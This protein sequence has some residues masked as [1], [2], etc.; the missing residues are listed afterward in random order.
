MRPMRT[1]RKFLDLENTIRHSLKAFGVRLNL[2]ELHM[3]TS[4][5]PFEPNIASA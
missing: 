2:A 5:P 4:P 1:A 3:T